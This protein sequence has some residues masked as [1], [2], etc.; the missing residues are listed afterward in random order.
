MLWVCVAN[1]PIH[2]PIYIGP[3]RPVREPVDELVRDG[4]MEEGSGRAP[5]VST[6]YSNPLC[7]KVT[8]SRPE[9]VVAVPV[10]KKRT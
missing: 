10:R 4:V 9:L 8:A 5:S 2:G 3:V 6:V 7:V 1:D